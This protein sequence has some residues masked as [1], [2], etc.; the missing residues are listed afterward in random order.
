MS[1]PRRRRPAGVDLRHDVLWTG[2]PDGGPA[3][4]RAFA[5]LVR[6]KIGAASNRP[7]GWAHMHNTAALEAIQAECARKGGDLSKVRVVRGRVYAG[8]SDVGSVEGLYR[9]ADEACRR[10]GL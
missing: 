9:V 10:G 3:L 1:A 5:W 4:R 6:N 7:V 8:P 2:S